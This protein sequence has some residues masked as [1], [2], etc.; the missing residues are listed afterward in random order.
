MYA[1]RRNTI[2]DSVFRRA[3]M[4]PSRERLFWLK[5]FAL[6]PKPKKLATREALV[7]AIIGAEILLALVKKDFERV[8]KI[9]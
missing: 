3:H 2:E 6:R 1:L 7:F 8:P 4:R 9:F 5:N